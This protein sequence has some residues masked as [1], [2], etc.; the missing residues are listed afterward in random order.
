MPATG[1]SLMWLAYPLAFGCGAGVIY[2]AVRFFTP[3]I[4]ARLERDQRRYEEILS[5][6]FVE[7]ISP[8]QLV[9]LR[10]AVA[11][12]LGLLVYL[13]TGSW[14]FGLV[15]GGVLFFAPGKFLELAQE[16]RRTKIESQVVD[17]I[18]SITA[19]TKSGMNLTQSIEEVATRMPPPIAQEFAMV[20]QRMQAGQTLEAALRACDE[21]LNIPNLS[22]IIQSIIVNEQR[23]GRL[24]E[25]LERIGQSLREINRVEERVKT[26]T[27]GIKL[28]SKIMAA[29]PFLIGAMLYMVAPDHIMMLFNTFLGNVVLVVA[30][31]LDWIGFT[32]IKKLSDLEV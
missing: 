12:G 29:M 11:P 21:R 9:L 16:R 2:T 19:T 26:E 31:I 18:N 4:R 25:L 14:L 23:G 6:L 15:V 27:S 10:Y 8:R 13:G 3:Q 28:S 17:L 22:L 1:L 20:L 24:P 32:I 30:G 7:G 5:D